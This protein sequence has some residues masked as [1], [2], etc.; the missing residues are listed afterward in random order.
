MA[1][2]GGKSDWKT[3]IAPRSESVLDMIRVAFYAHQ[4]SEA[5]EMIELVLDSTC[6]EG[7]ALEDALDTCRRSAMDDEVRVPRDVAREVRHAHA[8][9]ATDIDTMR[10]HHLGV[11]EHKLAVAAACLAMARDVDAEDA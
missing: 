10:E 2:A 11:H 8:A 6:F 7:I 3:Q 1:D 5:V 9:F 4:V